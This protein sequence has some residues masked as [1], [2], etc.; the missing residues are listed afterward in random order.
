VAKNLPAESEN[1]AN[2]GPS[3]P[4]GVLIVDDDQ[5]V[6]VHMQRLLLENNGIN[7]ATLNDPT[8]T[9]DKLR[10]GTYHII[11]LDLVMPGM[12][13]IDLLNQVRRYDDDIAIVVV[14][15]YPTVETAVQSLKH[16]VSD[17]IRKPFDAE[18]FHTTIEAILRK[19]GLLSNP[20]EELHAT[21]GKSI[22]QLRKEH[23]LTLKQMSRRTG[24]SVSLLSQIERAE[25]SASVSSL[26]KIAT[27]L[28]SKLTSLFG[29]F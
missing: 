12:H 20:E 16:S 21:I 4:I 2:Q 10:E 14:T 18:E 3:I 23:G 11:I 22:R 28:D 26:F 7:A 13:G 25:S 9:L 6:C 5:D 17:Y 15:G 19:K 27:A 29:S 1:K 8:K 24:L